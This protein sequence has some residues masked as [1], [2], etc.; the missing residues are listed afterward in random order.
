[1]GGGDAAEVGH[2]LDGPDG[3]AA[4]D[5]AV[6]HEHVGHPEQRDPQPL[7]CER[8]R[9]EPSQSRAEPA[10]RARA[11]ATTPEEDRVREETCLCFFFFLGSPIYLVYLLLVVSTPTKLQLVCSF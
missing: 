5:E 9:P 3:E 10:E 4:V 11:L 2:V 7:R 1:M 8:R 6:V